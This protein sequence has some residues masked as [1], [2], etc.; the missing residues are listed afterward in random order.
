M[1]LMVLR[2]SLW[3]R[4][5]SVRFASLSLWWNIWRI[6]LI[7]SSSLSQT[8]SVVIAS[9]SLILILLANFVRFLCRLPH[10]QRQLAQ[11]VVVQL[12]HGALDR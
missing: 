1:N 12:V 7:R 11:A 2:I 9:G 5:S 4:K 6:S 10:Q 3:N 8:L